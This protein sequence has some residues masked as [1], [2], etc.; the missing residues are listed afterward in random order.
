MT[1]MLWSKVCH[2]PHVIATFPIIN[3]IFFY[4]VS[5]VQINGVDSDSD[6][7]MQAVL[8]VVMGDLQGLPEVYETR[9]P[10]ANDVGPPPSNSSRSNSLN[11]CLIQACGYCDKDRAEWAE[12]E[13][14][15]D[16]QLKN[17]ATLRERAKQYHDRLKH[18]RTKKAVT[19]L[20]KELTVKG[21]RQDFFLLLLSLYSA[22]CPPPPPVRSLR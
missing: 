8:S 22:L 17:A 10:N 6:F 18:A 12:F 11:L 7:T 14:I 13:V 16:K 4:L 19:D 2:Y 15:E 21:E 3:L 9:A 1:S 5:G 20:Q